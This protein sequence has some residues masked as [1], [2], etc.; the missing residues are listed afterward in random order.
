MVTGNDI[1]LS[2]RE[3]VGTPYV[4]QGRKKRVG[5]DCIGVAIYAAQRLGLDVP[6]IKDYPRDPDGQ[7]QIRIAQYCPE[8]KFQ[9][10]ALV[11]QTI[12]AVPQHCGIISNY[13][14]DIGIIHAWDIPMRVCENR[15]PDEWKMRITGVFGLPGVHYEN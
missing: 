2:A 3:L 14:D 6:N 4:H 9:P 7:M 13:M 5:I 8:I 1:Y 10:G 11:V 12:S 15:L